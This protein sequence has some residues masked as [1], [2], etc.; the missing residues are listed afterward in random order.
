[1]TTAAERL[2]ALDDLPALELCERAATTLDTLV[3][4][5]NE[6]TVLLRAGRF[7]EAAIVTAQKAGPAQDYVALARSIQRQAARLQEQEPEAM[8]QLRN[9]HEK[10]ATQLAENL[11]V[12]ATARSVTDDLLTEVAYAVGQASRTRTYGAT[13][14]IPDPSAPAANG[15]A[16]NRAR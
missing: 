11:R 10:L 13:G 5:M 14:E 6:E 4:I 7:R 8:Q 3:T 15:I 12:I 16:I 2:N 9:G 1:M